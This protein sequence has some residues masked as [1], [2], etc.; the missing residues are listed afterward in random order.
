MRKVFRVEYPILF[1]HC[2]P[3]GSIMRKV[4]RV[5]YPI[6]FSHCDPAGIVPLEQ[7]GDAPLYIPQFGPRDR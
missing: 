1:S 3:A 7:G 2:D 5:E 6:L 4:F